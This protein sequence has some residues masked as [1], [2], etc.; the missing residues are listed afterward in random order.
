MTTAMSPNTAHRAAQSSILEIARAYIE[1]GWALTAVPYREKK[2]T[3]DGWQKLKITAED[4][5]RYFNGESNIGVIMGPPSGGLSDVDLDCKEAL[6]IGPRLLPQTGAIFG[7]KS[8]PRSHWLYTSDLAKHI[9]KAAMQFK[10]ID[11]TMMLELR[12]GGGGKGAQT[13]FPGSTHECGEPIE[14]E[15]QDNEPIK[16]DDDEL[17]R[18]VERV[19]VA[20]LLARHWP[21]QGSRHDA[22]LTV[23]GFLARAG[24]DE[25]V[26]AL[27]LEEIA[28]TAGDEELDDRV[29]AARDAAKQHN[30]GGEARGLPALVESFGEKV[31]RKAAEWLG[32]E[33]QPRLRNAAKQKSKNVRVQ[34]QLR[35]KS[36]GD[37][38]PVRWLLD[39][40]APPEPEWLVKQLIPKQG[41][42]L[43]SAGWGEGK[44]FIAIDLGLSVAAAAPFAG[45]RTR[46]AGVLYLA[47]ERANDLHRRARF[48][49]EQRG[50]KDAPF[51]WY[52]GCPKLT[53]ADALDIL[54]ATARAC[55]GEIFDRHGV[56]LGLIVIDTMIVA[57]WGNE[58]K[59]ESVQPVMQLLRKLSE[60]MGCFVLGVDHMGKDKERGTR[61]SSDKESSS[62]VVLTLAD[63]TM[64]LRKCSEGPQGIE[65]AFA[66]RVHELGVDADGDPVTQ[67]TVE[68][69]GGEDAGDE[70]TKTQQAHAAAVRAAMAKVETSVIHLGEGNYVD[71]VLRE[72]VR[73]IFVARLK[74]KS[75]ASKR[76]QWSRAC[77]AA[78]KSGSVGEWE[79]YLYLPE[80]ACDPAQGRDRA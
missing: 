60:E 35:N 79:M 50:L 53:E 63:G 26:A 25:D 7:R 78:V 59:S 13:V 5:P 36:G 16:I 31:G 8:K 47:V 71:A 15:Q 21:A 58:D 18:C 73:E 22:A 30:N 68:W 61:G 33:M 10:D 56:H 62:D 75:P 74:R 4:A 34:Q 9:D 72:D 80:M 28:K 40:K 69:R 48:A 11:G 23:G 12:I 37:A 6:V 51:L 65:L 42:G 66:L 19:A 20:A 32:Y 14:W 38:L 45:R 55:D 49:A 2:P 76:Q 67:C 24:L 54:I 17:V 29:R 1:R 57:G 3:D 27:M 64:T 52:G 41:I 70:L 39:G 44:T 46:P 77:K 43:M